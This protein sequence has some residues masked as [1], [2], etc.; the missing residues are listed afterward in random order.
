MIRLEK[1]CKKYDSSYA[2]KDIDLEFRNLEIAG[3][4]GP[5]GGG[6]SSLLRII[7]RLDE[8]TSGSVFINDKKLTAKNRRKLCLKIGMVFQHFNLFSHMDVRNNL[9]YGPMKVLNKT[10]EKAEEKALALLEI[11]SLKQKFLSKIGDLSG[12]QKQRIAICRALSMDPEIILFDEPTS[13]LD[14]EIVKDVIGNINLLKSKVTMIIVSHHVRFIKA[15]SDRIIFM[16]RG[17]VL[18]DQKNEAFFQKPASQR[19]RLFLDNIGDL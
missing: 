17:M 2:L 3:I 8:P 7:N 12:G 18:C 16:D 9:I 11:F 19:A 15:V 14:P 10:K 1:I 5:S 6:K 4:L 13:A